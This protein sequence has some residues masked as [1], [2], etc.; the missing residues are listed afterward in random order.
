[1]KKSPLR[2]ERCGTTAVLTLD[3]PEAGNAID[4]PMAQALLDAA[5]LCSSDKSIRCVILT[6]SGAMFCAGGD[7]KA[8][9]NADDPGSLIESIT[10]PLHAAIARLMR[11]E[12]PIV[13]AINGA[14][15]GAGFGLALLGDV[16]I[17]GRSAQFAVAYGAL[18][19]S[20]DAGTSWLLPRLVGLRQAQRLALQ[21]ERIDAEEAERIGLISRIVADE[22]LLDE[23]MKLADKLA[24]NSG[25][26]IRRTR[27]LLLNSYG[28]PLEAQLEREAESIAS[29]AREP[30]GREGISAFLA[31]R[32]PTFGDQD[33]K[34]DLSR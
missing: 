7:I 28:T 16:A 17:A 9:G 25:S 14:A 3:R 22:R 19:V 24:R 8:F 4:V 5:F 10:A 34:D 20:P 29:A 27:Q 18:G 26:A 32:R 2:L 12:K 13:T 15:A 31:K 23:A 6:G 1:M 21:G 30:D 33:I 11:M